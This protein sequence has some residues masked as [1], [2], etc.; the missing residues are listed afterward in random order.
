[1]N[2]RP[3]LANL[4][5]CPRHE[6]T[7]RYTRFLWWLDDPLKISL[8]AASAIRERDNLVY[9]SAATIWEIVIKQALDKLDAPDDLDSAMKACQFEVLPI[10]LYHAQSIR[11]L[12]LIHRDPFDR[13]LI[14]QAKIENL[15]LVT[16]DSNIIQYPVSYLLS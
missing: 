10:N 9:V 16:R 8:E 15:T 1:M 7:P 4:L 6:F 2:C 14:A 11:Q 12:P 13:M 3:K 5:G